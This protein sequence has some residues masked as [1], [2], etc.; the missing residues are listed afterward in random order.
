MKLKDAKVE[1]FE[2]NWRDWFIVD[3]PKE[4]IILSVFVDKTRHF[5]V[6]SR[7]QKFKFTGTIIE[8]DTFCSQLCYRFSDEKP[9]RISKVIIYKIIIN[10][11]ES[12]G[13]CIIER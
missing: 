2:D 7:F 8:D 13:E 11:D 1:P 3:E 6:D 5:F 12:I 9:N 10:R 4:K